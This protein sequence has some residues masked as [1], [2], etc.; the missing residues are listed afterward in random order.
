MAA[1]RFTEV[2]VLKGG[3]LLAPAGGSEP[4]AMR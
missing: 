4:Y 2:F 3:M 1:S